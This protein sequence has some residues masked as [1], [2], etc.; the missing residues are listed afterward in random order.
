L[1]PVFRR[2]SGNIAGE[3]PA[4]IRPEFRR[5]AGGIAISGPATHPLIFPGSVPAF[6]GKLPGILPTVVRQISR[7]L[8]LPC[9]RMCD[10]IGQEFSGRFPIKFPNYAQH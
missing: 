9:Q 4:G 2:L 8:P 7:S 10:A 3:L 6:A 1:S 5:N